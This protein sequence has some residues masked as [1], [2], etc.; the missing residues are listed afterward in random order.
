MLVVDHR[1]ATRVVARL[2]GAQMGFS[3]GPW[4]HPEGRGGPIPPLRLLLAAPTTLRSL[5]PLEVPLVL[6]GHAAPA[7][8]PGRPRRA[9][10]AWVPLRSGW[11]DAL[12]EV[13]EDEGLGA[14]QPSLRALLSKGVDALAEAPDRLLK[15]GLPACDAV[16]LV[17]ALS[18]AETARALFEA[19]VL[20][21]EY[22]AEVRIHLVRRLGPSSADLLEPVLEDRSLGPALLASARAL[23]D[24]VGSNRMDR[25]KR[26]LPSAPTRPASAPELRDAV[27]AGLDPMVA[28]ETFEAHERAILAGAARAGGTALYALATRARGWIRGAALVSLAV[29]ERSLRAV[30]AVREA[31]LDGDR[32]LA[33][34]G[35]RAA[36]SLGEDGARV[37]LE[38]SS[39]ARSPG[40]RARAIEQLSVLLDGPR[41]QESLR[42]SWRDPSLEVRQAVLRSWVRSV[43]APARER[44]PALLRRCPEG[45][46]SVLV[47]AALAGALDLG[48][49]GLGI[50]LALAG[51]AAL[52]DG[53]RRSAHAALE[54][55]D[56]PKMLETSASRRLGDG[57]TIGFA[58]VAHRPIARAVPDA[59]P[60]FEA[61]PSA[62]MAPPTV[63]EAVYEPCAEEEDE[64]TEPMHPAALGLS[65]DSEVTTPW[66]PAFEAPTDP[67]LLAAPYGERARNA[68]DRALAS[69]PEGYATLRAVAASSR[70][71]ESIRLE[72][73]NHLLERFPRQLADRWLEGLLRSEAG[74]AVQDRALRALVERGTARLEAVAA[75]AEDEGAPLAARL[76]AIRFLARRSDKRRVRPELDGLLESREPAVANAALLALFGSLR[77]TPPARRE[78]V[79]CNL[80]EAHR[81]PEVRASAA[82]ALGV[83]GQTERSLEALRN[84]RGPF[85]HPAVR[86][87]VEA[88]LARRSERGS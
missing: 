82:R 45:E 5:L 15:A 38:T 58:A 28:L 23:A 30:E 59:E 65:L 16:D 55:T 72:A 60:F 32:T 33:E 14:L 84:A 53:A 44:L 22:G 40:T 54:R 78:K 73:L 36:L 24:P 13:L 87:A 86:P 83:F 64:V 81:D 66:M 88:A 29:K 31:A 10:R 42:A 75:V 39:R 79:L 48:E 51:D 37:L 27:A 57:S 9:L 67:V 43:G 50:V 70:V 4:G 46:R 41:L 20:G 6:V 12:A 74:A 21:G 71:P 47:E 2:L 19:S 7:F 62:S 69:G 56:G 76:R 68:L 11:P 34:Q 63:A 77:F 8:L 25:T 18:D 3:L 49:A 61:A 26:G 35:L 80:L 52:P 1:P 85:A 17:L